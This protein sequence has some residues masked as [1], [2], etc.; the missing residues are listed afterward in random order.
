MLGLL[1]GR[2]GRAWG[3]DAVIVKR[4]NNR[5]LQRLL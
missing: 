2:A 5:W 4:W 3:I 1:I